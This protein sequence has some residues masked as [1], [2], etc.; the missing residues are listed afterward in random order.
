MF[1]ASRQV[2]RIKEMI[3]EVLPIYFT[4]ATFDIERLKYLAYNL[5]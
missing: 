1:L 2:M 5:M 3:T 4:L